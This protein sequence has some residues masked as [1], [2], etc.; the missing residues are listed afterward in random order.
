MQLC[1][2]E[3][4]RRAKEHYSNIKTKDELWDYFF[5]DIVLKKDFKEFV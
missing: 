1:F 4:Q 2:G 3:I 5:E